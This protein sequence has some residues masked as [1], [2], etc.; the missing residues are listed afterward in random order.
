MPKIRLAP[1]P[2]EHMSV[3]VRAKTFKQVRRKALAM[4]QTISACVDWLLA[5]ALR[6]LQIEKQEETRIARE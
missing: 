2:Q 5:D 6:Q 3:Y 4:N 1:G